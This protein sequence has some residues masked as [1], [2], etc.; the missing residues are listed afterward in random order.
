MILQYFCREC[1]KLLGFS[2]AWLISVCILL[3]IIECIEHGH[4][5]VLIIY[6]A[7]CGLYLTSTGILINSISCISY[8]KEKNQYRVFII[9]YWIIKYIPFLLRYSWFMIYISFRCTA[10][11]QIFVDH[12][13]FKVI[14]KYWL[15]SQCCI[16]I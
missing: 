5:V 12:I 9:I 2:P 15:Y 16:N 13:P 4:T 11:I 7:S 3:L 8:K 6:S 10:V 1:R 14:T